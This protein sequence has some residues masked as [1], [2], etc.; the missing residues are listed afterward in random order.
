MSIGIEWVI[1]WFAFGGTLGGVAERVG[2]RPVS[3]GEA[4]FMLTLAPFMLAILAAW[5][6]WARLTGGRK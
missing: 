5:C 2:A 1:L 4:M 6:L 3:L